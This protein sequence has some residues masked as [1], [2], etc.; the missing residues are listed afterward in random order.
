M[1]GWPDGRRWL[2]ILRIRP[3]LYSIHLEQELSHSSGGGGRKEGGGTKR[4]QPRI[5]LDRTGRGQRLRRQ[6]EGLTWLVNVACLNEVNK[7]VRRY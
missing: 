7:R 5:P 2:N 1:A 3:Q 6:L 4:W